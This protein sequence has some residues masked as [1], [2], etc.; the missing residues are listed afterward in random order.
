AVRFAVAG[1]VPRIKV[2]STDRVL[3][4]RLLEIGHE[5]HVTFKS[6]SRRWR[7]AGI[8]SAL[9]VH[10]VD[11]V[12]ETAV[13]ASGA[14]V[15]PQSIDHLAAHG[16]YPFQTDADGIIQSNILGT[17]NL[18]KACEQIDYETFVNTGSSSECGFKEH[19]MRETD[20]LEPTSYYAITK[21]EQTLLCRTPYR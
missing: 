10:L 11:L 18:L 20:L 14:A 6:S 13:R 2:G 3:C 7:L 16:A 15:P 12:D 1:R 17:W 19:A 8:E 4:R 9:R 5:V 21:C